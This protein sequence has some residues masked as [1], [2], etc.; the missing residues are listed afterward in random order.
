MTFDLAIAFMPA[1]ILTLA[2]V[3][4][5]IVAMMF[6]GTSG[7]SRWARLVLALF[8]AGLL[9]LRAPQII[10]IHNVSQ[11][12][13]LTIREAILGLAIGFA[14]QT[15]FTILRLA[16]ALLGHEMG[17]TMAQVVD[18]NTGISSPV[19][20]RFFET[21]AMLFLLAVN[22]HHAVF[23]LLAE[24]FETIPVGR[25]WSI[26]GV[27]RGLLRLT[28]D[29]MQIGVSL[30]SPIY[31]ALIL[32]TVV[33]VVLARAVPQIHLMEFGYGIRILLALFGM[34]VFLNYAAP[35]ISRVFALL[36]GQV[37]DLIGLAG[38]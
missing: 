17:F 7:D 13:V 36:F 26:E 14:F 3:S 15:I 37:R 21:M 16:G 38:A 30:A 25:P 29:G 8:L 32:L 12:V 35:H 27:Y 1:Y 33:L 23:R 31:A 10:A 18:P 6:L 22:G 11:L 2:R 20:G 4:A 19:V 34:A 28:G 24:S 9:F 5:M